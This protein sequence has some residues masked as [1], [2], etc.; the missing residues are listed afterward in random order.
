M[1]SVHFCVCISQADFST[2]QMERR[3]RTGPSVLFTFVGLL[4]F[5]F[6]SVNS[7]K[8]MFS[9]CYLCAQLCMCI[10]ICIVRNVHVCIYLLSASLLAKPGDM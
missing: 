10:H 7:G 2:E 4:D 6:F 9:A 5:F 3:N 8:V 1:L